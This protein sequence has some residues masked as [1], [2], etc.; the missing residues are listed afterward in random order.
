[1]QLNNFILQGHS[2]TK[3]TLS[4]QY[5]YGLKIT[6]KKYWFICSVTVSKAD[7]EMVALGYIKDFRKSLYDLYKDGDFTDV[8]NHCL[9]KF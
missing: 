6:I 8:I 5:S 2:F 7:A 4:L 9:S 1:M 3:N